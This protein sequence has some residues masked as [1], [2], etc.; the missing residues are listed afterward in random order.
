MKENK[1]LI[2][3]IGEYPAYRRSLGFRL[4]EEEGELHRF[5]RY[6]EGAGHRG[7]LA[8]RISLA[9]VLVERCIFK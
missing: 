6:V 2:D 5:A 9:Y 4:K 7:P 8:T 1:S 3:W